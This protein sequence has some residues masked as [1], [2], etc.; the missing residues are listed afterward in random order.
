MLI[1][2]LSKRFSMT[3]WRVGFACAPA[4][5]IDY[6]VQLNEDV[7]ACVPEFCQ[8]GAIEALENG[9][10]AA[11]AM[12]EGFRSRCRFMAEKLNA[13]PGIRCN[14]TAGTFYLFVDI[15]ALGMKSMDFC[16]ELLDKHGFEQIPTGSTWSRTNNLYQ[17]VGHGK[18]KLDQDRLLGFLGAPWSF[19]DG[20]G[21]YTLFNEAN[22]LYLARK[23]FYPE[24]LK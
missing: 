3:G 19:T 5:I 20:E 24:T 16:Y 14:E 8:Y 22:K 7:A 1:E 6:M 13:I 23:K 15:R 12:N 4:S 10:E 2:S 11:R 17:T 18:N 21:V 9:D